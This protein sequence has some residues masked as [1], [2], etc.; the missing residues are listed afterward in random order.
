MHVYR[1]RVAIADFLQGWRNRPADL[2]VIGP[3]N[4]GKSQKQ[5]KIITIEKLYMLDSVD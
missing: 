1:T 2:V 3:I 4:T 5:I